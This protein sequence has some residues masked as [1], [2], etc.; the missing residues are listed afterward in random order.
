VPHETQEGCIAALHD[1]IGRM[2]GILATLKPTGVTR[3]EDPDNSAAA[4]VRL[5]LD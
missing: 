5:T 1:E 2:R 4:S 3:H